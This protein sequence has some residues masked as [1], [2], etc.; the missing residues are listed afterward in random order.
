MGNYTITLRFYGIITASGYYT[1][2][3]RKLMMHLMKHILSED[4]YSKITSEKIKSPSKLASTLKMAVILAATILFTE[5]L[6]LANVGSESLLMVYILSVLIISCIT[7]KYVYGIIAALVSTFA[8][9]LLITE[10]RLGLSITIGYPITLLTMLLVTFI[11]STLTIQIRNQARLALDKEHRAELLY[12]INQKLLAARDVDT[13]IQLTLEY[14]VSHLGRAAI[15]YTRDPM[16]FPVDVSSDLACDSDQTDLFHTEA[17]RKRVHRIMKSGGVDPAKSFDD[18]EPE[19]YY[20]TVAS[21]GKIL[22]VIGLSCRKNALTP[23]NLTFLQMLVG[24]VALALELQYLSDDQSQTLLKAEREK[25]R[26]T[27]LRA[28]SHD[29]RAPLTSILGAS[30]TILEQQDLDRKTLGSLA[31][32]IKENAG[33]LIR[34]VENILT[35]TKISKET[36]KVNKT[37]EAAEEIIAQSVSIVRKR[38]PD[39]QIHVH[40][41]DELLLVPM[42]PTLISQVLINLMENAVK[43]SSPGAL[44][45]VNLS[46][47]GDLAKFDVCD[48]GYGIP[49]P[50]L[51]NLFS[52]HTPGRESFVDSVRG[53]GIGLSICQAIVQAHGGTIEGFNR[54]EGGAR[55]TFMLP[56]QDGET[57]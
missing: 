23:A 14:L 1:L 45:L 47:H 25:M 54:K 37:R 16:L 40:T 55:F 29:L 56:L 36:L 9:D 11:T 31:S 5:L 21:K 53:I 10:P 18:Y 44:I 4:L 12:E 43:N 42:D 32:D 57:P 39:W 2:L 30:S 38:F 52:V 13:I 7:P 48:N 35:I 46:R 17:E 6:R 19:V 8:F 3:K 20:Q 27:L 51:D 28:I 22:G 26:S 49:E 50:V 15:F 24:Q 33:W 41:L 34:M